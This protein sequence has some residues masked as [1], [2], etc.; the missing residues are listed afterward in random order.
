MPVLHLI[1]G[2]KGAGRSTLYR[3]L[4][5]RRYPGLPFANTLESRDALLA[6]GSDFATRM[7]FSRPS[8][9]E[10]LK[11]ARSKGFAIVLYVVC[12]DA[13][14]LLL[15][16]VRQRTAKVAKDAALRRIVTH[17][18]RTLALLREGV[19]FADL[20]LL[21]DGS[22]VESGGPVLVAAVAAGYMHLHMALRPRWVEKVLGFAE[23]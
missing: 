23:R 4:I 11:Q 13:P 3:T 18:P 17:Y 22:D 2:P 10:L 15:D 1:A 9:L 5:A 6:Q 14:W 16:R 21:F 19:E 20:A 8:E 12:V 7:L